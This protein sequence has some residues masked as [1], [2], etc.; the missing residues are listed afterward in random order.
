[1]DFNKWNPFWASCFGVMA[2]S[3]IFGNSL[4]I[5]TLLKKKFRKGSHFLLIS[6]ALA[7]LLVGCMIPL[8]MAGMIVLS[9][10]PEMLLYALYLSM[11]VSLSSIFHLAVISLERLH[12]TLRPFRHRQLSLTTYWV[13]IATPWI[14]SLFFAIPA[15]VLRRSYKKTNLIVFITAFI[16]TPLLITCFSY[17]VIWKKLRE[18]RGKVRSFRQ[19]QEAKLSRIIFL[20]TVTSFAT[21][22][23]FQLCNIVINLSPP[24][25]VP[26]SAIYPIRVLRLSNSFVNFIIYFFRFPSYRRALYSMFSCKAPNHQTVTTPSPTSSGQPRSSREFKL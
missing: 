7:D 14:V 11:F 25:S 9:Y 21:W 13:A 4:T 16:T 17:I 5:A 22:I 20:V 18:S 1:M 23:P 26:S 15:F 3:I 8:Y 24:G 10:K 6:L 2:F 12:A 19:N